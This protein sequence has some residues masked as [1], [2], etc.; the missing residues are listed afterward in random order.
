[1]VKGYPGFVNGTGPQKKVGV[2]GSSNYSQHKKWYQE[3]FG[4]NGVAFGNDHSKDGSVG[5]V[6]VPSNVLNDYW[7]DKDGNLQKNSKCR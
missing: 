4:T 6:S 5:M 7:F 3:M 1:M 2:E